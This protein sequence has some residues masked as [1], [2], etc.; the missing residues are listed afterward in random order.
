MLGFV[1]EVDR[2]KRMCTVEDDGVMHY[3]VRLQCVTGS[4]AGL[5][6]Y[7][8]RGAA[9]LAVR[10]E[11]TEQW[12]VV[13]ASEVEGWRVDA[14]ERSIEMDGEAVIFNGGTVGVT[15]SDVVTERLNAVERQCNTLL[16]LLSGITVPPQ[17]G[18][19]FAPIFEGVAALQETRLEDIEDTAVKH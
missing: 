15:K 13:A 6:I 9:V 10:V 14:G 4:E 1:R 2:D 3:G 8:S 18:L 11:Q 12:V 5:V 7:P 16:S 17:G 19:V